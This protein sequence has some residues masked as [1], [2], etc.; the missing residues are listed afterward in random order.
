MK[1]LM[2]L[3]FIFVGFGM[4]AQ[5]ASFG[6]KGGLNYGATGEYESFSQVSGDFTSSFEDG[7]NKTGFHAGL[8][9]Q[10]EL[11]GIFIQPELLYTELNTEYSDFDYKLSKIDAPVLVG[12][13]VLGP[14]NIKAGPSFQYILKN[15]LENT[16]LSIEKVENDITVGYQ[17]GIGLD[18]GRLGFDVRHEGS[19]QDNFAQGGDIAADSGFTIDSRP[20]QWILGV[21]YTL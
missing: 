2:M 15:E 3:T 8:F 4:S 7:E 13:N 5:N 9:A 14:L 20:S 1:K 11:L 10:F 6:I 18:L 19:F 17:L 16:Q 12:I 21:S